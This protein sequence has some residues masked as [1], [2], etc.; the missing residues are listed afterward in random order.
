MS[1]VVTAVNEAVEALEKAL[2][3]LLEQCTDP[4]ATD[5]AE[6]LAS[7]RE[8][9]ILLARLELE[10]E[11]ATAKAML[12]DHAETPTLRVE[13]TRAAERKTWDHEGWQKDVR[14]KVLR[15]H[16]LAGVAAL[17]TTDGEEVP[18]SELHAVL[19]DLQSVH[20]SAGP[21]LTQLRQFGLDP[22]DY[23][24]RAPGTWR[25]KVTRMADETK[26]AA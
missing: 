26:G 21:R 10:T 20:G 4:Q 11:V 14:S 7:I 17:I 8:A 25:V 16:G 19:A 15:A 2:P 1:D 22:D 12:G 24:A 6:V 23:C 3:G 13:R 5:M 18:A 9:R